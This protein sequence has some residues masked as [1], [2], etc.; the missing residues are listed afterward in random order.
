MPAGLDLDE[1]LGRGGLG[2]VDVLG[3]NFDLDRD[4]SSGVGEDGGVLV[5]EL[6]D[7]C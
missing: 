4:C 2:V 1:D 5:R 7:L 6:L 3:G